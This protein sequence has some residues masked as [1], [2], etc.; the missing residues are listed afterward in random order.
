M[1]SVLESRREGPLTAMDI[2]FAGNAQEIQDN[3]YFTRQEQF[4]LSIELSLVEKISL[5]LAYQ[6]PLSFISLVLGEG[7]IGVI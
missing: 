3:T 7:R 6:V 1:L 5:V 4:I 2:N